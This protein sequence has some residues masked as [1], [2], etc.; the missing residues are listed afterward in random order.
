MW[1]VPLVALDDDARV[2]LRVTVAGEP[3]LE[4]GAMVTV[5]EMTARTWKLDG[6]SG[7]SLRARAITAL[8][9][10]EIH[11]EDDPRLGEAICAE[12]FDH[13]GAVIWNNAL[14]ELWRR[15]TIHLPR[16]LA[17]LTG[18]T[19]DVLHHQVRIAYVKVVEYQRRGL[20]RLHVVIRLDRAMP[21]YRAEE[22]KPPPSR[23]TVELL[24]HAVRAAVEAVDAPVANGLG[25]RVRWGSEL[26]VDAIG[27]GGLRARACASYLAKY[28]TKSTELAGGVVHR[29]TAHEL[30][31]LPVREHVRTYM[32]E[33]F[34]LAAEPRAGRA[35]L[36]RYA[37]A[38]G[39]RG[40]CVSKSRRYSTTFKALR[41]AREDH[42]RARLAGESQPVVRLSQLGYSGMGHDTDSD[43]FWAHNEYERRRQARILAREALSEVESRAG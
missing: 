39:Y 10:N 17:R 33:A 21:K 23:F 2:V 11:G 24:E 5:E 38:I 16:A 37:H 43:A 30:D 8:Y 26:S 18:V 1:R 32:R 4:P 14:S 40:H 12:C 3:E 31:A 28:S 36:D 25:E 41:Q 7:V 22:I 13:R 35:A 42:V 20:M 29:V 34:Q 19:Q 27:I 9:C 15:T 6:R